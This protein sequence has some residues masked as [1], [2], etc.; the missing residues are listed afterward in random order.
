MDFV[1]DDR[2]CRPTDSGVQTKTA[3]RGQSA[4]VRLTAGLPGSP[5][6]SRSDGGRYSPRPERHPDRRREPWDRGRI[7]KA[8][9]SYE[10]ALT[11]VSKEPERRFL[12]WRLAELK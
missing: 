4:R 1:L 8:R 12:A 5:G 9:A 3:W 7:P 2:R 10:E 6:D 11:L